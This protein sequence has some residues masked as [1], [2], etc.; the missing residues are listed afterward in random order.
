M[1][2]VL[3]VFRR[4]VPSGT[5]GYIVPYCL[6]CSSDLC[7]FGATSLYKKFRNVLCKFVVHSRNNRR[8][9]YVEG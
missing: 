6:Y 1:N 4:Y 9:I 7:P 8:I 2:V 3:D 5:L